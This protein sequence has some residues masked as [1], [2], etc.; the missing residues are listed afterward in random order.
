METRKL[1]KT[2]GA[3]YIISLPKE[4]IRRHE[5]SKGASIGIY[6]Q[7][8]GSLILRPLTFNLKQNNKVMN[9][10]II[11]ENEEVTLRSI[12]AAYISGY[13]VINILSNKIPLNFRRKI[14][15]V[16]TR[17]LT[18]VEVI[19]DS[20]TKITLQ[21]LSH[22]ASFPLR[23][24]ID[25][26]G[27]LTS[28]MY[29]DI[30]RAL[31]ER[32]RDLLRDIIERDDDVDRLYFLSIRQLTAAIREPNILSS[33]EIKDLRECLEYRVI[34]RHIERAADHA[35]IASTNLYEILDLIDKDIVSKLIEMENEACKSFRNSIYSI[36]NTSSKRAN[37]AL[38]LRGL[39]R[40]YEVDLIEKI[41]TET[42]N[43]KV[44][45]YLRLT[46]ESLRRLAEYAAGI[47]EILLD[48]DIDT[49]NEANIHE[50]IEDTFS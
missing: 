4:W 21:V 9:L 10:K 3:T 13:D 37:I 33:L 8:D 40:D 11:S 49:R 45:A 19:E 34:V 12:I 22:Y 17:K 43:V 39:V 44:V 24:V 18:G 50:Q 32:D 14:K 27:A 47:A 20:S 5:L 31:T 16:I 36:V 42:S 2:G 35:T 1:V 15:E 23:R 29:D 41:L 38:S 30:S 48:L 25:R 46:I 26:M 7:A 6:E 28:C